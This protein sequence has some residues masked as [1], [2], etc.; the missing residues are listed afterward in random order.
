MLIRGD[1]NR[2]GENRGGRGA[3]PNHKPSKASI[4]DQEQQYNR[5]EYPDHD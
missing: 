4:V 2:N 1:R 3:G 5:R